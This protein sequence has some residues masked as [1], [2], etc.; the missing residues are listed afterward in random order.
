MSEEPKTIEELE[1][2]LVEA[3]DR[4][5]RHFRRVAPRFIDRLDVQITK[6]KGLIETLRK[7]EDGS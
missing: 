7:Q 6:L 5:E 1:D 2:M 4:R 3:R